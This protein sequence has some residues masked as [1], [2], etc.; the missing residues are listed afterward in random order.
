MDTEYERP[1]LP[2]N[3]IAPDPPILG[4]APKLAGLTLSP[5]LGLR[6][7]LGLVELEAD[8]FDCSCSMTIGIGR[9]LGINGREG[10]DEGTGT[11]PISPLIESFRLALAP[12]PAPALALALEPRGGGRGRLEFS[13]AGVTCAG[14]LFNR[15]MSSMKRS[16]VDTECSS[17]TC[18]IGPD[19]RVAVD[20]AVA[21]NT[22]GKSKDEVEPTKTGKVMELLISSFCWWDDDDVLEYIR[23]LLRTADSGD[24]LCA[25]LR[26][27]NSRNRQYKDRSN[28]EQRCDVAGILIELEDV[29]FR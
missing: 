10:K 20:A 7:R 19:L 1:R 3:A 21:K 25:N 24:T 22:S 2:A 26:E 12:A 9:D 5:K 11:M 14:K 6:P 16:V 28:V 23:V 8:T 18:S 29:T 13:R 4:L 17:L 15:G 27:G